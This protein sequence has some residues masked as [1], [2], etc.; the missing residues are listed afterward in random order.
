MQTRTYDLKIMLLND[1]VP[2]VRQALER[3]SKRGRLFGRDRKTAKLAEQFSRGEVTLE[4]AQEILALV[5]MECQQALEKP[6]ASAIGHTSLLVGARNELAMAVKALTDCEK[7]HPDMDANGI[8]CLALSQIME[9][10]RR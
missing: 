9:M 1:Y 6:K 5:I 7:A 4:Q 8:S 10:R 3:Q 2:T